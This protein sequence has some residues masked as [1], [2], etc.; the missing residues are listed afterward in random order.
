MFWIALGVILFCYACWLSYSFYN[1]PT[2]DENGVIRRSDINR[3]R[4]ARKPQPDNS[5]AP[6]GDMRG[7][8]KDIN[9]RGRA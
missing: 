5:G 7:A 8:G 3:G 9:F 4:P 2:G 6:E 1:A